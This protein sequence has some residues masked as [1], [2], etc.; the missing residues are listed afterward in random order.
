MTTFL[1]IKQEN[2][3]MDEYTGNLL[4]LR[5]P[6]RYVV[7]WKAC[8]FIANPVYDDMQFFNGANIYYECLSYK[9]KWN[10]LMPC[11]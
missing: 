7:Q 8:I 6:I 11:L 2:V 4:L 3:R 9:Y 10:Y 5:G 1:E